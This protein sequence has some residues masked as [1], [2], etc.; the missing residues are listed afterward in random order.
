MEKKGKEGGIN[1]L[2]AGF[3]WKKVGTDIIDVQ[4]EGRSLRFIDTVNGAAY[5]DSALRDAVDKAKDAK[6]NFA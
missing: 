4:S 3:G 2:G 5:W 6:I 1:I